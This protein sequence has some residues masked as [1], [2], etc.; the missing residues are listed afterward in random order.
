MSNEVRNTVGDIKNLT[1]ARTDNLLGTA[2]HTC[3]IPPL[4]LWYYSGAIPGG[5]HQLQFTMS[6]NLIQDMVASNDA[7]AAT[8]RS[9]VGLSITLTDISL[10]A[11]FAQ[12]QADL[13]PPSTVMLNLTECQTQ[14]A[15][16]SVNGSATVSV[17]QPAS[18]KKV[19]IATQRSDLSNAAAAGATT[20]NGL[21]KLDRR[22]P[23]VEHRCTRRDR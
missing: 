23:P 8:G 5:N 18:T 12:P 22:A 1:T 17:S 11:A 3:F 6:S 21:K 19:A 14:T 13:K 10:F 9:T 4:G 7:G 15:H 2:F 20:F 16:H